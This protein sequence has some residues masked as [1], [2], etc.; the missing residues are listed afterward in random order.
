VAGAFL[1]PKPA[2]HRL[3]WR[4][5]DRTNNAVWNLEWGPLKAPPRPP[6]QSITLRGRPLPDLVATTFEHG[7]L[8]RADACPRC[9][10][11]MEQEPGMARCR[12]GCGRL[13]PLRGTPIIVQ[14]F[15]EYLTGLRTDPS[16]TRG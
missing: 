5:G 3:R 8:E 1:V 15:Y 7:V 4:D 12:L 13:W 14:R 6:R 16:P 2:G 10:T 11:P 9:G